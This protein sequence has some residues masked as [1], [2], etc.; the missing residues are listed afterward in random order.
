MS[1]EALLRLDKFTKLSLVHFSGT[2]S[3]DLQ[4]YLDRCHEV[5]RNMG[6]IESNMVDFVV[7]QMAGSAKRWWSD[8]VFTRPSDSPYETRFVDLARHA[9]V[10]LPTE[11]ERV[12]KFIDGLTYTIRLQIA[13]ET[14]SDISFQSA[15]NIARR[16]ELVSAQKRGPVSDKRPR[17]SGN[18]TSASSGGMVFSAHS[19]PISALPLQSHYSC[20][21]QLQLQQPWQKDGCYECGNIG[22][23]RRHCP[24]FS[25]NRSQQ[26]SRA[27]VPVAVA[28]PPAQPARSRGQVARVVSQT[29]RGG[30]QTVRGGGQPA[31]VCPRGVV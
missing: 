18:L 29:V 5:L 3:E 17:H 12:R 25:S 20:S 28:P 8:Y 16:I 15:V 14:G 30:G 21:G 4:D 31:S 19:A 13:K 23:I 24:R 2:P 1:S 6:I 27:I 22:H 9:I 10:L 26:D 7:F 11:K